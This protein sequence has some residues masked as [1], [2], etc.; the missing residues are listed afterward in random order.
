[1]KKWAKI[2]LLVLGV[3]FLCFFVGIYLKTGFLQSSNVDD[4]DSAYWNY[5][6]DDIMEGGREFI[7][8]GSDGTC[9]LLIHGYTSTPDEM[10][11][12]AIELNS[13][14]NET[15]V[16]P[17][18]LGHAEV[19]SAILN[20]TLDDWYKQIKKEHG[21]MALSC[22]NVNVVGFS[23]GG[24]IGLRLAEEKEIGNL[25]ILA[26]YL[27]ARYKWFRILPSEIYLDI[28]ADWTIYSKKLLIAQINSKDGLDKHLAYWNMPF[29]PIKYS[30]EFI[31]ETIKNL[32]KIN[33]SLLIQHSKN[34][35]TSDMK[36]SE[37]V[38]DNVASETKKLITL[39]ESNH[40]LTEDH[41][42]EEVINNI[43]SF[44]KQQR[45]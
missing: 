30:A 11:E 27:K 25:Y 38:F 5:S 33:E 28:F 12:L 6:S 44:E 16:V 1:M 14:F 21:I 10:K 34:D 42:K 40:V 15:V 24:A 2:T 7:L 35:E 23:F 8:P 32:N 19:P 39:E 17:R 13:E 29:E 20:F 31:D 43:I 4:R 37:I 41:D 22:N 9:W 36:S 18:L 45:L 26:P 3:V